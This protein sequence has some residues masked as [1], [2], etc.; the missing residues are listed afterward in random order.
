MYFPATKK[1]TIAVKCCPMLFQ[2]RKS[3]TGNTGWCCMDTYNACDKMATRKPEL[4]PYP[5]S[6]SHASSSKFCH[7]SIR[8][9]LVTVLI[10][11]K[12][13]VFISGCYIDNILYTKTH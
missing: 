6:S 13:F 8:C 11:Y 10:C 2:L 5:K 12:I 9:V 1:P 7:L 4:K 3:A